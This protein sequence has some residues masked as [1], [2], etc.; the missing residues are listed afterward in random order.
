MVIASRKLERLQTAAEDMR[1]RISNSRHGNG[2]ESADVPKLSVTKCN[3]REE[4]EVSTTCLKGRSI[5]T[6]IRLID[7]IQLNI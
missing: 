7:L 4:Q 6:V 3:I 5:S 2:G 1:T